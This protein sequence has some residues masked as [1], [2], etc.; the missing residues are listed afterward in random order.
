MPVQC[1]GQH[2]GKCLTYAIQMPW[3]RGHGM[4]QLCAHNALHLCMVFETWFASL[5]EVSNPFLRSLELFRWLRSLSPS[6]I[7]LRSPCFSGPP[8]PLDCDPFIVV[9]LQGF[10]ETV[11]AWTFIQDS[12]DIFRFIVNLTCSMLIWMYWGR[13]FPVARG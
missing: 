10:G 7:K 11:C 5:F 8:D 2:H 3:S 4:C 1:H 12:G 6:G 13:F 9:F